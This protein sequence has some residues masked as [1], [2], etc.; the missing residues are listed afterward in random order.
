MS[1]KQKLTSRQVQAIKTKNKIYKIAID[2]M[3]KKGFENITIEEISKKAGV[4]VGAFYHYFESKN[5]ILIE[6]FNRFDGYFRNEV[7]DKLIKEN[8]Y[9]QIVLF[10]DYYA[11][12]CKITGIDTTKQVYNTKNKP[13]IAK[14]RY[15]INLLNEIIK[16]GQEKNQLIKDMPAEEIGKYMIIAA[17]GIIFDWC[18]HEGDY[19]IEEATI[20][21]FKRL[22]KV[23][24]TEN[25]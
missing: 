23:F 8:A 2:L 1:S 20:K 5:D 18:L 12:Y 25:K 7:K 6:I 9:D 21:Y 13:F 14:D 16:E 17:R 4:S 15:M 22:V 24:K 11:K 19:D 10:F 3:E